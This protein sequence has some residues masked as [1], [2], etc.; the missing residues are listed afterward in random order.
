MPIHVSMCITIRKVRPTSTTAIS[1]LKFISSLL[2]FNKN[3]LYMIRIPNAYCDAYH[4][5]IKIRIAIKKMSHCS[6][7][8]QTVDK[9]YIY[10]DNLEKTEI[11]STYKLVRR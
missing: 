8:T 3:K 6:C 5:R 11:R 2:F 4:I 10:V 9:S 7:D 1:L